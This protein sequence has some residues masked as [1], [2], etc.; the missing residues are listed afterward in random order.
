MSKTL[1]DIL[2]NLPIER[3]QKI[4]ERSADLVYEILK[5]ND[6]FQEGST[7][8]NQ[9]TE[10]LISQTNKLTLYF[11]PEML[12]SLRIL[13]VIQMKS[14]SEI[15]R[16]AIFIYLAYKHT[17]GETKFDSRQQDMS[18]KIS[19]MMKVTIYLS[20][21]LFKEIT[22]FTGNSNELILCFIHNAIKFYSSTIIEKLNNLDID[23]ENNYI[24]DINL[25]QSDL[26]EPEKTLILV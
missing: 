5:N 3:R 8:S 10:L 17:L 18:L 6:H 16:N 12:R 19:K 1:T 14:V 13:S 26:D 2:Q 23:G 15:M 22:D 7:N 24:D 20:D 25:N 11:F 4:A 9:A 21:P